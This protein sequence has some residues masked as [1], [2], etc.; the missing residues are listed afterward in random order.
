M[1]LSCLYERGRWVSLHFS[2]KVIHFTGNAVQRQRSSF[3]LD[4][5]VLG[6]RPCCSGKSGQ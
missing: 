6:P 5:G 3:D 4:L 2:F 1:I